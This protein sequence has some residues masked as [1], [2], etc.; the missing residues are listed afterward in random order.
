MHGPMY[1]KFSAT[2]CGLHGIYQVHP[3][4][5]HAGHNMLHYMMIDYEI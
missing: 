4:E 3:D 1:I 2:Y 5:G